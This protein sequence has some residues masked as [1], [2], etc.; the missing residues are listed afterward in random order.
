[1]KEIAAALINLISLPPTAMM[2][3][4]QTTHTQILTSLSVR[5]Q[6]KL[7]LMHFLLS[8]GKTELSETWTRSFPRFKRFKITFK[9]NRAAKLKGKNKMIK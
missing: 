7:R 1:M 3:L 9:T 4:Y 8:P 6:I 2:A 5:L